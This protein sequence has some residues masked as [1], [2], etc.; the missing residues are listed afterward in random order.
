MNIE[1]MHDSIMQ[2]DIEKV[3]NGTCPLEELKHANVLVTG[4]TGL[5]GSQV[6]KTLCAANRI[7][8]LE[9]TVYVLVRS[10]EKAEK[11]FGELLNRGDIVL[12]MGDVNSFTESDVNFDYIVHAASPTS[13]KYFVSNPV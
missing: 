8:G 13:S 10:K 9:I 6:V 5:I 7:K 1:C 4:A 11:V 12:I 3:V 2:E